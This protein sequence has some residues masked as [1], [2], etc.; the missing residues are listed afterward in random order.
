MDYEFKYF[1][2]Y[3][4]EISKYKTSGSKRNYLTGERKTNSNQYGELLQEYI[5]NKNPEVGRKA[6]EFLHR[7]SA[8]DFIYEQC[9]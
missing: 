9:I 8:I 4:T 6:N 7:N 1:E 5:S 2:F 3:K